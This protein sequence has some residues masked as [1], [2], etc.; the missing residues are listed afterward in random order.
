MIAQRRGW[1]V[2]YSRYIGRIGALA[3]ALGV[4]TAVAA[5]T[6]VAWAAPDDSNAAS[7]SSTDTG[8]GDTSAAG[9]P[10]ATS[11][12]DTASG[13]APGASDGPNG[14]GTGAGAPTS[15]S[16]Q[17]PGQ[18]ADQ[19]PSSSTVEV[20]SGVTISSSGGAHTSG[21]AAG[22]NAGTTAK[23]TLKPRSRTRSLGGKKSTGPA[24]STMAQT[25]AVQA[26]DDNTGPTVNAT[27]ATAT[28]AA[29]VD[30]TP[31]TLA[32]AQPAVAEAAP[33]PVTF[34]L[35][36]FVQPILSSFL[37]ALPKLPV[38]SPLGWI[39]L[40]AARRQIGTA[41]PE[42]TLAPASALTTALIENRPP[43][44]DTTF[45]TPVAVTGVVTGQV[46]ATDPDGKALTYA[47]TTPPAAGKVV[48]DKAT[49]KFTYTPT[50]AQRISAAVNPGD[51]T[52]AMTITVSDGTNSVPTV[53]NVPVSPAPITGLAEIGAVD[54]T[55]AVVATATRAYVTNRAAGTVTVIDTTTNTVIG[56]VAVGLTP[57]S[58]AIKPDGTRLYVSS[59]DNNTVKVVD[60]STRA[61]IK[62]ITVAKPSAM[63]INSSGTIPG[64]RRRCLLPRGI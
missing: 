35:R 9:T 58:L 21:Q 62:T 46:V 13:R 39:L 41:G 27:T 60:T 17:S 23:K 37:G 40:A 12:S 18:D 44:V 15:H 55:H 10:T 59:L 51:D 26:A 14:G 49:A 8:G 47:L 16:E 45:D 20:A 54:D 29:S 3:V 28:P 57:D 50:T 52:I 6:G 1:E 53:V 30:V 43:T 11:S 31:M 63:A 64:L 36:N 2:G 34:V 56:T 48:F 5:P 24:A 42:T 32:A 33:S 4:G 38:E 61:V 22:D 7:S 25:N 19:S